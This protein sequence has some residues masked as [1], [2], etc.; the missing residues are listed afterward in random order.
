MP[1]EQQAAV[2]DKQ[3]ED[4][5]LTLS[6]ALKTTVDFASD[7]EG[8]PV[9]PYFD[10]NGVISKLTAL[11]IYSG[12]YVPSYFA[13]AYNRVHADIEFWKKELEQVIQMDP[14]PTA[15]TP[16]VATISDSIKP[17]VPQE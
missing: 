1:N 11:M 16:T 14:S 5:F 7:G 12:M 4:I 9:K 6:S 8:Q 10:I 17:E 15:T 2:N 13:P 3:V